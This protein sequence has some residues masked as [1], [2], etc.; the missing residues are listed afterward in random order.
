MA[1]LALPFTRKSVGAKVIGCLGVSESEP[2]THDLELR[3]A[4]PQ[5]LVPRRWIPG[6]SQVSSDPRDEADRVAQD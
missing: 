6:T 4:L 5:Q 1:G 3:I 2:S